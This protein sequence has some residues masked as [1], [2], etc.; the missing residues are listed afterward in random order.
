MFLRNEVTHTRLYGVNTVTKQAGLEVWRYPFIAK[1]LGSYFRRDTG[2][3]GWFF[4]LISSPHVDGRYYAVYD[5]TAS[6]QIVSSSSFIHL[7]LC[8]QYVVRDT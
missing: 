3:P 6:V 2:W 5:C 7:P 1:A 4:V 8:V